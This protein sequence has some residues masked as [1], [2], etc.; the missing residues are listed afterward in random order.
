MRIDTDLAGCAIGGALAAGGLIGA[1]HGNV[2][3][4]GV[5]VLAVLAGLFVV[6]RRHRRWPDRRR[7]N[8]RAAAIGAAMFAVV[9]LGVDLAIERSTDRPYLAGLVAAAVVGLLSAYPLAERWWRAPIDRLPKPATGEVWWALVP[10]KEKCGSKD[11][12][13]LVL[14][15]SRRHRKVLMFTSQDKS[16]QRGYVAVPTA[17]WPDQ[18]HS[19]LKTDRVITMRCERFRRRETTRVP[20]EVLAAAGIQR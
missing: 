14:S 19:F 1:V 18:R 10:F 4:G 16:G 11:R 17:M 13:C 3:L 15:G 6:W 12:P 8:L 9:T 7:S 5:L 20:A 2:V